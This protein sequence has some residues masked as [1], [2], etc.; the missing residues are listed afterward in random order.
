MYFQ[1]CIYTCIITYNALGIC[2]W[3]EGGV[4]GGGLQQRHQC[5]NVV[6]HDVM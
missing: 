5:H 2:V 4:G 6:Y 3:R 1:S